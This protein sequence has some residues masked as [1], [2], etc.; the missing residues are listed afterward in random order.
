MSPELRNFLALTYEELEELNLKAKD[1]R[2]KRVAA[3]KIQEEQL[4]YLTDQKASRQSPSYSATSKAACT[5]WTMTK[6]PGKS[7]DNLTFDGRQFA[8]LP[9]RVKA[10]S[11]GYRLGAFYHAPADIFGGGK[12][13]VFGEVID[14][15]G[16]PYA[17]DM[18]G[19]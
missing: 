17:G 15:S 1:Q 5:C 16:T 9:R 18:R 11:V 4:K 19:V 2:R 7:N 13:L 14:K 10:I 3:D 8:V 6:V 12:V